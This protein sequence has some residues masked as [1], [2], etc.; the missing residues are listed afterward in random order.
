[1]HW[2]K[3]KILDVYVFLHFLAAAFRRDTHE[4]IGKRIH[5]REIYI[6]SLETKKKRVA[7][8]EYTKII[9][10]VRRLADARKKI[11]IRIWISREL[12][13]SSAVT[14]TMIFNCEISSRHR[15]RLIIEMIFEIYEKILGKSFQM[16]SDLFYRVGKLK[17]IQRWK[18]RKFNHSSNNSKNSMNK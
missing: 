13:R 10:Q 1:M 12:V 9:E 16:N 17:I 18:H 4:K 14:L 3:K 6:R 15:H 7:V 2:Q 5:S 8:C 11:Y